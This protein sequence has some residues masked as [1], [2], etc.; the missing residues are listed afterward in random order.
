LAVPHQ[1]RSVGTLHGARDT[2]LDA[3][4]RPDHTITA[5]GDLAH[6]ALFLSA[7]GASAL[8]WFAPREFAAAMRRFGD[9]VRELALHPEHTRIS[10]STIRPRKGGGGYGCA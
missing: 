7:S 9:F 6:L 8:A 3:D 10:V 2:S 1:Q 4:G 5:R